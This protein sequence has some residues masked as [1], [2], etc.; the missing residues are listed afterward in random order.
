[1]V[2]DQLDVGRVQ[3]CACIEFDKREGVEAIKFVADPSLL[4]RPCCTA[5]TMRCAPAG[6]DIICCRW[7][8]VAIMWSMIASTWIGGSQRANCNKEIIVNVELSDIHNGR[9]SYRRCTCAIF[10]LNGTDRCGRMTNYL[11]DVWNGIR[12]INPLSIA[13]N[14]QVS[15]CVNKSLTKSK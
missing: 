14:S 1:M 13:A 2:A 7:G 4:V 15:K 11:S 10:T 9:N 6:S 3:A 8:Q 12:V 5:L